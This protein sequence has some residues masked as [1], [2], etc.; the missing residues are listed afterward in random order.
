MPAPPRCAPRLTR[1]AGVAQAAEQLTRNEQAKGSSPFSGSTAVSRI[2]R[3][4]VP[5]NCRGAAGT[6]RRARLAGVPIP[7]VDLS[8]QH[9]A[10]ADEVE[11]GWA[12]VVGSSAFV[13][14]AV[15][16]T[17]ER[18]FAEFSGAARCVSVASGTDALELA[19][20]AAGVGAGDA[21]VVPV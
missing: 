11:K 13:G 15:I 5:P 1:R 3:R 12:E 17:F 10:I 8:W 18:E 9:R 2:T 21:V 14:G 16:E 20:R 19:L 7:L 4:A 6:A